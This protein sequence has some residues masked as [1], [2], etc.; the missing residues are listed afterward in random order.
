[1]AKLLNQ[2]RFNNFKVVYLTTSIAIRKLAAILRSEARLDPHRSLL[3]AVVISLHPTDCFVCC[4]IPCFT[5]IR[6]TSRRP[7]VAKLV[8]DYVN[9]E[10]VSVTTKHNHERNERSRSVLMTSKTR[11]YLD[12]H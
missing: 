8:K 11:L 2:L 4:R 9:I 7:I 3:L 5:N 10:L 12:D 6:L 1:M